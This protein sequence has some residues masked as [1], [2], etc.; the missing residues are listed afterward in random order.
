MIIT[1]TSD[2]EKELK[3]RE[4]HEAH[5]FYSIKFDKN[6]KFSSIYIKKV[7]FIEKLI[8][9]GFIRYDLD[10]ETFRLLHCNYATLTEVSSFKITDAFQKYIENLEDFEHFKAA[11]DDPEDKIKTTI[12]PKMIKEKV[13]NSLDTYFGKRLLERLIPPEPIKIKTD[14]KTQK[15]FYFKNSFIE[16]TKNRI[17]QNSYENLNGKI[18]E[19]Q[20]LQRDYLKDTT[21]GNYELFCRDICTF[22]VKF[23]PERFQA[24]KT[25]IGYLMHQFFNQK[26]YLIVLTDSKLSEGVPNGRTG[27]TL[28]IKGIGNILNAY[29]KSKVFIEINGKNFDLSDKHRM[30]VAGLETQLIHL[31]DLRNRFPVDGL[32]N[33]ITDGIDVDKKNEKPFRIHAKL[34]ASTNM[35]LNVRGE[36]S[37]D[38]IRQFE[39]SD[40]Y[41]SRKSPTQKYEQWFFSE[42]WKAQE[43]NRFDTFMI[44]CAADYMQHGIIEA[45]SVNV[46]V[47]QLL[48]HTALEFVDWI[49]SKFAPGESESIQLFKAEETPQNDTF[50]QKLIDKKEFYKDFI[51]FSGLT[52]KQCNNRKFSKWVQLV[53]ELSE[54]IPDLPQFEIGENYQSNRC[55]YW[56]FREPETEL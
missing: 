26:L 4:I 16:V 12:T 55:Y 29:E 15:F 11:A 41:N 20:I 33:D 52:D 54:K 43:W 23:R 44:S 35:S 56:V 1:K 50:K 45:K 51:E 53:A 9:L 7:E 14:T 28:L 2:K 37:Y 42:D 48:D 5:N 21:P 6:G 46:H 24:L 30:A 32:F 3:D 39:F 49:K 27:K 36:S 10:E 38:R 40:Y 8:K 18:F 19:N 17:T 13:F 22:G 34:A 31:N 47:R 25:I